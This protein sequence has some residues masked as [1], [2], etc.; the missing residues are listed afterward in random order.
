[1]VYDTLITNVTIIDGYWDSPYQ[2]NVLISG[3]T[4]EIVS[5][6]RVFHSAKRVIDG[7]GRYLIPGI[8]DMHSH[9]DL[10]LVSGESYS[11]KILQGITAEV[12]GNC[13]VGAFPLEPD[14]ETSS[15][16]LSSSQT[17]SSAAAYEQAFYCAPP[18]NHAIVLQAHTP[19]RRSVLGPDASRKATSQERT[20]MAGMLA[21]SFDQGV[22][23]FST[24]LYYNPCSWAERQEMKALLDVVK[25]YDG[26]FSVH[27][28]REG[29]GVLE[30]LHEA[31]SLAQESG[32]RLQISHLKAIGKRNQHL[33]PDMLKM[34]EDA[35]GKGL[36][37]HFDQYPYEWGSTSL[38]S[39]L[40]PAIL[41]LG[42]QG[43]RDILKDPNEKQGVIDAIEHPDGY[44]SLVSL[45]GF[46]DIR[47]LSHSACPETELKSI[48]EIAEMWK[49]DPYDALFSLL[50]ASDGNALISDIT[51]STESLEMILS[52][53]L[54][55][56]GTDAIYTGEHLHR[57]C[58]HAV[59]DILTR[60]SR[61]RQVL[62]LSRQ[63]QRM[64]AFPARILRLE[65][66][67][68]IRN[69]Y[70]AD[71]VLFDLPDEGDAEVAMVMVG[72][73]IAVENGVHLDGYTTSLL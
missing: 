47:I 8:I 30:S 66:R 22:K 1:M 71:L 11:A 4:I 48:T 64:C 44:E 62:P 2:G 53:P 52:H 10:V 23:G 28:R 54:G 42:A 16:I 60:F 18:S 50:A 59:S 39:L 61:D 70:K 26:L 68:M 24:G 72:G 67:G 17:F 37:V 21:R 56:F 57:R 19:L 55:T 6:C 40:P 38:S 35:S 13:G 31:I 32:V 63:I 58:T 25:E 51:Q 49:T 5:S 15:D 41:A 45:V 73:M 33:V 43:I 27:H 29:D 69:G 3:D 14:A 34:I 36:D 12:V 46:D 9:S 7:K 20:G 65:N